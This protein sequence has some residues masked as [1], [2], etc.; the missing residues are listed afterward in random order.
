MNVPGA[1][2]RIGLVV[3]AMNGRERG[4]GFPELQDADVSWLAIGRELHARLNH[5]ALQTCRDGRPQMDALEALGAWVV[6]AMLA[7]D[8]A[9]T[10]DVTAGNEDLVA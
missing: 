9:E 1:V 8:A 2:N 3:D 4:M 5:V 7:L 6:I 10:V